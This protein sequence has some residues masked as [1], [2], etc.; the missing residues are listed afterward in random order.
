MNDQ[1]TLILLSREG[2]NKSTGF[3]VWITLFYSRQV[4]RGQMSLSNIEHIGKKVN[5]ELKKAR[6]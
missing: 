6:I 4:Y 2:M 5:K 3:S 1:I